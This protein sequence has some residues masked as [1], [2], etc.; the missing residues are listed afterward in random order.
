MKKQ[1]PITNVQR[2]PAAERLSC[3]PMKASA[4][5]RAD[6]DVQVD[7]AALRRMASCWGRRPALFKNAV[8]GQPEPSVFFAALREISRKMLGRP[9]GPPWHSPITLYTQERSPDEGFA[10]A[11]VVHPTRHLPSALDL[12]VSGYMKRLDK[13]FVSKKRFGLQIRDMEK[14]WLI[15]SPFSSFSRRLQQVLRLADEAVDT[16]GFL[17]NY[18]RTPFGVHKDSQHVITFVISG[19]K[20]MLLW[21]VKEFAARPEVPP[22]PALKQLGLFGFST[23]EFARSKKRAIVLDCGPGDLMYWPPQYWHCADA[24]PGTAMTVTVGTDANA[25]ESAKFRKGPNASASAEE[26]EDRSPRERKLRIATKCGFANR[27]DPSPIEGIGANDRVRLSGPS[28]I[29]S[30]RLDS[31]NYAVAANGYSTRVSPDLMPLIRALNKGMTYD[32]SALLDATVGLSGSARKR[33]AQSLLKD[34]CAWHAVDVSRSSRTRGRRG[35]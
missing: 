33:E 20:R 35:P 3:Q 26:R 9:P 8:T 18:A 29:R 25:A 27:P 11:L 15:W 16:V 34:L 19:R 17:G 2:R 28:P 23:S 5:R 10:S 30:T 7:E 1:I 4:A 22:A 32:A 21:P 24:T 6:S 14:E 31:R 12:S 13:S